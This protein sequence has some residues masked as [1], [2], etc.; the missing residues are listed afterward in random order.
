VRGCRFPPSPPQE[1]H[2]RDTGRAVRSGPRSGSMRRAGGT[3]A[4]PL[5]AEQGRARD[6]DA[7]DERG[8]AA[9]QQHF[10]QKSAHH[11]LPPDWCF[12]RQVPQ[13]GCRLSVPWDAPKNVAAGDSACRVKS[14]TDPDWLY[15]P[16]DKPHSR[17]RHARHR[18][19]DNLKSVLTSNVSEVPARP[20]RRR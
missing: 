4:H 20:S 10:I 2:P 14:R 18:S 8:H 9:K 5:L 11:S 17:K 7:R 12:P 16:R 13:L 19:V 15:R 1:G 3:C 6:H